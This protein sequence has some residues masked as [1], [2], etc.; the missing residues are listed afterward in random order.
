MA[1][2]SHPEPRGVVLNLASAISWKPWK[3]DEFVP[4]L[5]QRINEK[6]CTDS[7]T[8]CGLTGFNLDNIRNFLAK[9]NKK[10]HVSCLSCGMEL[11]TFRCKIWRNKKDEVIFSSYFRH[12]PSWFLHD[13]SIFQILVQVCKTSDIPPSLSRNSLHR[14]KAR[15][16]S[17]SHG[18]S[19]I[20]LHISWH[21]LHIS[22]CFH[23]FPSYSLSYIRHIPS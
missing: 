14:S 9:L 12:I 19:F 21:F 5:N 16:F 15:N 20:F 6:L 17:K 7:P 23:H 2:P 1:S 22:S 4:I 10:D 11:I 18:F 3:I 8:P 13:S